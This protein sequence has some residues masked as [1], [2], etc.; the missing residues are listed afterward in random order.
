MQTNVNDDGRTEVQ[1]TQTIPKGGLIR[2]TEQD[3]ATYIREIVAMWEKSLVESDE[4][5]HAIR[6]IL[7]DSLHAM[8]TTRATYEGLRLE[9]GT[10]LT[11][12]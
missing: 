2:V 3:R 6:E 8:R 1:H 12:F 9:D 7:Q 5:M 10:I 4:A 11:I